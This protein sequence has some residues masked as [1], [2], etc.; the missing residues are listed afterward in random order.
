MTTSGTPVESIAGVARSTWRVDARGVL[1]SEWTKFRSV[2]SNLVTLFAAAAALLA[3]GILFS[4][5]AGNSG[6]AQP[7]PP[8]DA[9]DSLG[10]AFSGLNLAQLILG[11]L[12]ALVVTSEYSTG[13]I[14]TV[15]AAVP[16]RLP[17]LRSKAIVVGFAAW[18][19][20]TIG[21]VI[22]FFVAQAVYAGNQATYAIGDPGVLRVVFGVGFFGACVAVM[23]VALGFILRNTAGAVA[24]LIG[25]LLVLP[26][27]AGLLPGSIGETVTKVLPSNA[28]A[29]FTQL[30]SSSSNLAP[31]AGFVVLIAWVVGLVAVASW[32]VLR[33][34]A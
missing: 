27:L 17:V 11:V 1:R 12:G 25:A 18:V 21:S 26:G 8:Q 30:T 5:L 16:K 20:M 34:D 9:T 2:R 29:A 3:F 28:G 32:S 24:T 13:L 4:V 23:G 15:F 33:R 22:T 19:V 7:G 6:A 10:V 31:L 14:R